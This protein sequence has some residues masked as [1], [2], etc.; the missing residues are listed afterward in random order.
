M[1]LGIIVFTY[2]GCTKGLSVFVYDTAGFKQAIIFYMCAFTVLLSN[3]TLF[4][5]PV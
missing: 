5:Q 2:K 1:L 3:Q 4:P